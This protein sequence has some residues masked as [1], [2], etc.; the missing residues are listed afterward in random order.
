VGAKRGGETFCGLLAEET[1]EKKKY[2]GNKAPE[3][4]ASAFLW[5]GSFGGLPTWFRHHA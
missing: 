5:G 3:K 2:C 4:G 1:S